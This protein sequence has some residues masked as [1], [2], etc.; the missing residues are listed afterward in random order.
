MGD[1]ALE[2]VRAAMT[3]PWLY[4]AIVVLTVLDA[5]LPIVPSEAAVLLA[6]T[7]AATQ[8]PNL[9]L[10]IVA[11]A[12]GAV[13]GDHIAYAAGRGVGGRLLARARP[14]ST[15]ARAY[16]WA[17]D[18]TERRGGPVLVAAR[19]LPGGRT[20]TTI[21]MGA[22]RFPLRRFVGY[23]LVACIMWAVY[24]STIGYVGG[25]LFEQHPVAGVGMGMTIALAVAGVVEL[26]HRRRTRS[27]P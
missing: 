21:T 5:F 13:V 17:R 1:T 9:A 24:C 12:A 23:D 16:A 6:G 27:S 22:T 25:R 18:A 3:S 19:F 10:V 15:T 20:A 11:G 8:G 2:L 7:F 14:G 4:L 26:T